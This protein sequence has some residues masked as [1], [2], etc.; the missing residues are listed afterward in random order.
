LKERKTWSKL[1]AVGRSKYFLFDFCAGLGFCF[2]WGRIEVSFKVL[3]SE[4]VRL[5]Q[6]WVFIQV[7]LD[8]Y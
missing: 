7:D 5:A 3:G 4:G 2:E 8:S 1:I 6:E